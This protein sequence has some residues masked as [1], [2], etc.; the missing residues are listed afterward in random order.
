[1]QQAVLDDWF[2]RQDIM[3]QLVSRD[4]TPDE[5]ARF[6]DRIVNIAQT[7]GA[8][9]QTLVDPFD[10]SVALVFSLVKE[11]GMDPWNIDLS[12][13]LKIF[14][15]R[16]RAE[17][18]NLDLPACG[19]LIRMSWEVLNEQ[20]SV[21]FDKVTALDMDDDEFLDFGW[22]A[23]YDDEEF[24][25]TST[26]LDGGADGVLPSLF[27]ERVRREE[28]RPSTLGELLSALKD[29][30][31]DAEILKAREENR[32]IHAKELEEM[33][34]NVGARMH[35]EDLEGDIEKCWNAIRVVTSTLGEIKVP[36]EE[37]SVALNSIL[38]EKQ[39]QIPEGYQEESKVTSFIAGLFLTHR[40]YA[41]I[42]QDGPD[43]PI[44]I[45]DKWPDIETFAEVAILARKWMDDATA[46]IDEEES[47]SQ[48]HAARLVERAR[49]AAEEEAQRLAEEAAAAKEEELPIDS[50]VMKELE[51]WLVE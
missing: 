46:A 33:I 51:T 4:E 35:D 24:I 31:D 3:D 34:S 18:N 14:T 44:M 7:D 5:A 8:E 29:A 9:H 36:V 27:G 13:F 45:E 19:R 50:T 37:V 12:A 28:G 48:R 26:V 16:V 43:D 2:L 1:M 49:K 11:E 41:S 22:E 23:E 30:C 38:E 10:R 42:T 17:A 40:G 39:G 47:E 6:A 32:R 25:F 21:L 20:A 15:Q